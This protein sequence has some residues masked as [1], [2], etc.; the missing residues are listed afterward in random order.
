LTAFGNRFILSSSAC[1][2]AR[3][4]NNRKHPN[5][6]ING[7]YALPVNMG[8]IYG[9]MYQCIF[10][11]G[12]YGPYVWLV[13]TGHPYIRAVC[14]GEFFNTCTYGSYIWVSKKHPYIARKYGP[15]FRV[16]RI[17][18]ATVQR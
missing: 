6:D 13:R 1:N 2:T 11:T 9:R 16:V 15:Y 14:M 7:R 8:R 12:T 10:D 3:N 18:G 17:G 5:T 4:L